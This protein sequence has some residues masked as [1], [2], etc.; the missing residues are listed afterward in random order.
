MDWTCDER[1]AEA[2]RAKHGVLF[3]TAAAAL[4]DPLARSDPDRHPGGDRWRTVATLGGIVLVI[5]H[6]DPD[7]A[8]GAAGRIISARRAVPAERRAHERAILATRR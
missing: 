5:I 2:N 8:T 7:E 6:I 1:K 4:A 3:Q